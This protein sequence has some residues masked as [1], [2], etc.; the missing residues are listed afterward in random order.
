MDKIRFG[1]IGAAGRGSSYVRTLQAHAATEITALC[2]IRAEEVRQHAV[3]LGIEHAFTDAGEMI[4]AGVVDAV[5]VGTPMPF[6]PSLLRPPLRL[7]PSHPPTVLAQ[8]RR[9]PSATLKAS[10]THSCWRVMPR[11]DALR[12][13]ELR[14]DRRQSEASYVAGLLL[15]RH[16]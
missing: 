6:H 16:S 5:V 14:K 12:V 4:D 2:D 15:A 1:I 13:S 11:R 3:D 7:P 9:C 10:T 8:A